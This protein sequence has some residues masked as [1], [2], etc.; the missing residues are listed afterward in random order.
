MIEL[1][2]TSVLSFPILKMVNVERV[3][4]VLQEIDNCDDNILIPTATK[5]VLINDEVKMYLNEYLLDMTKFVN[6]STLECIINILQKEDL[7]VS[8][9][10]TQNDIEKTEEIIS[11]NITTLE[12][13]SESGVLG[14]KDILMVIELLTLTN[15]LTLLQIL[16][17]KGYCN[18]YIDDILIVETRILLQKLG[19]EFIV[20]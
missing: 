1:L 17:N 16:S 3:G 20:Y 15:N 2:L 14:Q 10:I 12:T 5:A 7:M 13:L 11:S 18:Y 6:P 19:L 9:Q 4:K 8:T